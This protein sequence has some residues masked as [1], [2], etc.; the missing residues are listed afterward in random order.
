MK[1]TTALSS[2]GGDLDM[3]TDRI[4][5]DHTRMVAKETYTDIHAYAHERHHDYYSAAVLTKLCFQFFFAG[6]CKQITMM[7]AI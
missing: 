4:R 7:G 5:H 6:I 3:T 2:S 1:D